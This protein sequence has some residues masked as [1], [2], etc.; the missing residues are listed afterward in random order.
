MTILAEGSAKRF[1][2][3]GWWRIVLAVSLALNIVF[4]GTSLWL[5]YTSPEMAT[6]QQRFEQ[7]VRELQLNDD[8]RD[9]LRQFAI[10]VRRGMRHLNQSNQPLLKRVWE[11]LAKPA[12]DQAVISQLVDEATANRHAYQQ[13]IAPKLTKFLSTLSQDQRNRFIEL[14]QRHHDPIAWRLRRLVTP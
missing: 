10:E 4:V 12:P 3:G 7:I 13:D 1:A 2:R 14:S 11:E 9:S 6:P 8:Q 5:R